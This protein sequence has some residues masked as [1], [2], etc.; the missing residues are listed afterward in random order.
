MQINEYKYDT[1]IINQFRFLFS[2]SN[3]IYPKGSV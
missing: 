3:D 2:T 1:I